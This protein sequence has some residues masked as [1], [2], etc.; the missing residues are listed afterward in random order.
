MKEAI[1]YWL[2]SYNLKEKVNEIQLVQNW[3]KL[4]GKTIA[5]YTL[6]MFVSKG[7]LYLTIT[8]APLRQELMYSREKLMERINEAIEKDFIK[9]IIVR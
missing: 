9:E 1:Q 3:E 2:Q 4:L 5:K 7:M 8:S 6:N